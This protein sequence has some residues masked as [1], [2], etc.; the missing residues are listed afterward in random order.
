MEV[1]AAI[2]TYWV[3]RSMPH[4]LQ[5]ATYR[6]ASS[7]FAVLSR[8]SAEDRVGDE[9]SDRGGVPREPGASGRPWA[10]LRLQN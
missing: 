9:F 1:V 7:A 4:F 10:V 8:K 2:W 3:R 6:E 5:D